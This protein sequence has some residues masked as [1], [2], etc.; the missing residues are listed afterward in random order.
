MLKNFKL[1]VAL[2]FVLSLTSPGHTQA[3]PTASAV[4]S[5]QIGG[6]YT[7][8][9]PDYGQFTIKGIS[10]FANFDFGQHVGIEADIHYIALVTPTDLAENSYLIGPRFI[11]PY[12]RFKIYAKVLGGIGDL[13]IQ[14][15]QDNV[16]TQG[17]KFF[18][19]AF[20]GGVD[21]QATH[22]IVVRAF[23]LETQHWSYQNGLTPTVITVGAAYRF[24]GMRRK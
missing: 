20:G 10:G 8:A 17:G 18:A 22:H 7:Y 16:G 21:I 19:Y 14:E 3:L 23:D 13:A 2:A 6:G 4:G 1:L 24:G 9:K 12:H 15:E 11:L 5:L